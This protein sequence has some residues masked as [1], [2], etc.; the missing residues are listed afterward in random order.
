LISTLLYPTSLRSIRDL[1]RFVQDHPDERTAAVLDIIEKIP[2]VVLSPYELETISVY[3][4][5]FKSTHFSFNLLNLP[6][7]MPELQQ[8]NRKLGGIIKFAIKMLNDE[9]LFKKEWHY[10]KCHYCEHR[11]VIYPSKG[12]R[13]QHYCSD[14]KKR[15][16]YMTVGHIRG[17]NDLHP[18]IASR[19]WLAIR[20]AA[21]DTV[22]DIRDWAPTE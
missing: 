18:Y 21:E 15:T 5:L 19:I 1:V 14:N 10:G 22:F 3:D 20:S 6:A 12:T 7:S 8:Y 13:F 9:A 2:P 4:S 17:L 16:T 11:V